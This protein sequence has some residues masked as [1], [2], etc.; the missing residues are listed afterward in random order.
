MTVIDP[1]AALDH[2]YEALAQRWRHEERHRDYASLVT[3]TGNAGEPFHR[4]FRFKEAYSHALLDRILKDAAWSTC[5]SLSIFD[6]F[7]GSGTTLV[8]AIDLARRTG[9]RV[10]A[11]GVERNPVM[12]LIANAKAQCAARPAE[13]SDALKAATPGFFR[14]YRRIVAGSRPLRTPSVTLNNRSYFSEEAVHQLIALA[15]AARLEEDAVVRQTLQACVAAAVEPAGKVRKD[16]R[17][18]RFSPSK[19]TT[20]P[21]IGFKNVLAHVK[22]DVAAPMAPFI[23][24]VEVRAGDARHS[25]AH[26]GGRR[27]DW[28]VF[29]PPYPNNIDYTE[30]YKTEAWALELYESP[31]DMRAQR[32]STLRSHPSINFPDAY[33]FESS[34][35]E[36]EVENLVQPLL[37]A[38]PNDRYTRGRSQL[39]RGYVD[40]MHRVLL[41]TRT[42]MAPNGRAAVI[43]GN[44][45]HGNAAHRF[46]VAS[47]LLIARLAELS[48]WTVDE[49]RV[50]RRPQR[51]PGRDDWLRESVVVLTAT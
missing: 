15:R 11:I 34:E 1:S 2:H 51:R 46:V 43:V 29:S 50:A 40:D 14:R 23:G 41:D 12:H 18:L 31:A 22:A 24:D 35:H 13:L 10:D 4:W 19:L 8:S 44:S 49:V 21:L 28:A 27:F 39:I 26:A 3:P 16:G 20:T 7:A 17:A 38:V 45:A 48:G 42:V 9:T 25:A 36:S 5:D 47:D 6:P 37:A 32:L 33:D 30:V